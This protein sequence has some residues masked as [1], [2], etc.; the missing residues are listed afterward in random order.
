[1]SWNNCFYI[2]SHPNCCSK[3][4][5]QIV[6]SLM[7]YHIYS[8]VYLTVKRCLCWINLIFFGGIIFINAAFF[9]FFF[10]QRTSHF[11]EKERCDCFKN[12]RPKPKLV[13]PKFNAP[14]IH[15]IPNKHPWICKCS[16]S[17]V[18]SLIYSSGNQ[19]MWTSPLLLILEVV[20]CSV[21]WESAENTF[22]ILKNCFIFLPLP[23]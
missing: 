8:D 2:C 18:T 16:M 12:R 21:L 17:P 7:L 4:D 13:F 14:G 11:R 6:P 20:R 9:F 23:L 15:F 1:M 22:C 19:R 10:P 3:Q 5:I